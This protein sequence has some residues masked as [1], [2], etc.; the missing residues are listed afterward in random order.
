M[1][2]KDSSCCWSPN[3][4]P[5]NL[6]T[7]K[8]SKKTFRASCEAFPNT[9]ANSASGNLNPSSCTSCVIL[10]KLLSSLQPNS[11]FLCNT[12]SDTDIY[13]FKGVV[14]TRNP[15]MKALDKCYFKKCK[16]IFI[17]LQSTCSFSLKFLVGLTSN[18]PLAICIILESLMAGYHG[19]AVLTSILQASTLPN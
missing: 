15:G 6:G 14:S 7:N 8:G 1:S 18:T 2:M 17:L 10:S 9:D 16:Q 19:G 4:A 11:F 13:L 3:D 12:E 5:P